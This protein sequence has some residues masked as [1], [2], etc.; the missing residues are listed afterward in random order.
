MMLGEAEDG[1]GGGLGVPDL[2]GVA[3]GD[4]FWVTMHAHEDH[5]HLHGGPPPSSSSSWH[6]G[7]AGGSGNSSPVVVAADSGLAPLLHGL[8]SSQHDHHHDSALGFHGSSDEPPLP[9]S[10]GLRASSSSLSSAATSSSS[11]SR[12]G[13][14][15][16]PSSSWTM[17]EAASLMMPLSPRNRFLAD[18]RAAQPMGSIGGGSKGKSKAVGKP[19][20]SSTSS[21]S[22]AR[23]R[24]GGSLDSSCSSSISASGGGGKRSARQKADSYERKKTRAKLCRRVMKERFDRLL[25]ALGDPSLRRSDKCGLI[26]GAIDTITA[27]RL[28]QHQLPLHHHQ[29]GATSSSLRQRLLLGAFPPSPLP[30]LLKLSA[31]SSASALALPRRSPRQQ[32]MQQNK[33]IKSEDAHDKASASG[34]LLHQHDQQQHSTITEDEEEDDDEQQ[35]TSSQ[36]GSKRRA[37]MASEQQQQTGLERYD[38]LAGRSS[39]QAGRPSLSL[40]VESCWSHEWVAGSLMWVCL[41]CVCCCPLSS[42]QPVVCPVVPAAA[43]GGVDLPGPGLPRGEPTSERAAPPPPRQSI[44]GLDNSLGHVVSARSSV[45]RLAGSPVG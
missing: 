19:K 41:L 8:L 35:L 33:L 28:Q 15:S 18:D 16:R 43:A 21:S 9:P 40:A 24:K 4:D 22:T 32:Q 29:A 37:G 25:E 34:L 44:I 7:S 20:P 10:R 5:D 6:V 23:R 26:T 27:L 36:A 39:C 1:G 45:G 2:T 38:T 17:A 31:S 13:S 3:M 30:L 14:P 12:M 42:L 11:P